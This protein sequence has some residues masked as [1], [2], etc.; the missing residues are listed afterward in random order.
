[1][2]HAPVAV[3]DSYSTKKNTALTIAAPGILANDTDSDSDP[4]TAVLVANVS[5]GTLV[6]N[7]NGSFTYTPATN[8]TGQVTFTYKAY[9]GTAYSNVATVT[10]EVKK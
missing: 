2:N 10:I 4:L 5:G 7:P 1:M 6:L 9:D 8:F 3:N